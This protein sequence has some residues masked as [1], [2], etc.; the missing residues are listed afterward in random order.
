MEDIENDES[1]GFQ[2]ITTDDIDDIGI[3]T[4][5]A[6]IRQRVGNSPVYLRYVQTYFQLLVEVIDTRSIALI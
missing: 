6:Q 4:I 2:L 3:S 1:A 5:I